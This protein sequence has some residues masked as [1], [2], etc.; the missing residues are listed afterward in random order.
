M[1]NNGSWKSKRKYVINKGKICKYPG[2]KY[3]ATV[4]GYCVNHYSLLWKKRNE[5]EGKKQKR[6]T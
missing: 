2:C 5:N 4:K 3:H 6:T 1:M